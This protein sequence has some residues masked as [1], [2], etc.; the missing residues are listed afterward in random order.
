MSAHL[1]TDEQLANDALNDT[2]H[3]PRCTLGKEHHAHDTQCGPGT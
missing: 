2:V 3:E 1:H